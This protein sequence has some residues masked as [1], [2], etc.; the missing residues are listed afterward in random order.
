MMSD[1]DDEN[2]ISMQMQAKLDDKKWKEL[3]AMA[4]KDGDGMV[5]LDEFTQSLKDFLDL[6]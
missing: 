2:D 6:S 5:S 4:D 3:I 1:F